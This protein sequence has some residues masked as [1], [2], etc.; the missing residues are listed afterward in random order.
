M[1]KKL[2][3]TCEKSKERELFHNETASPDGKKNICKA[4]VSDNNATNYHWKKNDPE[5]YAEYNFN[6]RAYIKKH[7]SDIV[8]PSIMSFWS[9]EGVLSSELS[10]EDLEQEIEYYRELKGLV[11]DG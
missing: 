2:C 8:Y 1:S 3:I 4:C 11:I 10:K 9:R 6:R 5:G 7:H